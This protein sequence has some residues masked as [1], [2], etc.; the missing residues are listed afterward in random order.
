MCF[1]VLG[2]A[3]G[4]GGAGG[5][6]HPPP[7]PTPNDFFIAKDALFDLTSRGKFLPNEYIDR[8]FAM[9]RC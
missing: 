3:A 4:T 9:L 1:L 6:I 2:K 5:Q 7:P 8:V